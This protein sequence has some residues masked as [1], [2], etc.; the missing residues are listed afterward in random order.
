MPLYEYSCERC[1]KRFEVLQKFSDSPVQ[2]HEGCGGTVKRLISPS[3]FHFKGSGFYITDYAG[4]KS[5]A[6]NGNGKSKHEAT[7][8]KSESTSTKK[9]APASSQS[10][11]TAQPSSTPSPRT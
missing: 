11:T 3:A 2:T 10:G 7:E 1:G 4:A 6:N 8:S 9:E 5:G